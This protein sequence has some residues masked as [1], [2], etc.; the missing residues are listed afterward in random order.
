TAAATG[1]LRTRPATSKPKRGLRL[2]AAATSSDLTTTAQQYDRRYASAYP[3]AIVSYNFTPT[4]SARLSYSRRV[5]RPNP[6]QLSPI[7]FHQDTRNV[8]RGNPELRA[9]YTNAIEAGYQESRSWGT[10]QLSPYIRS[11]DHTA[12]NIHFV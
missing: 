11:T 6:Y 10:I 1:L 12:P 2:E 9:E 8:F 7:E 4:R 5:S 3:S